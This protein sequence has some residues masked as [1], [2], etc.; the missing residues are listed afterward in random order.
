MRLCRATSSGIWEAE[1]QGP[2]SATAQADN[3]H[4]LDTVLLHL[5]LPYRQVRLRVW[6]LT[7]ND[8]VLLMVLNTLVDPL[9][10]TLEGLN[11][12]RTLE[13]TDDVNM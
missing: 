13:F 1:S 5:L 4:N 12:E 9:S 11:E 2:S 7:I 10:L 6:Y 3:G 8:K